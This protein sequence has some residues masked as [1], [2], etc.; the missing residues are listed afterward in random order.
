MCCGLVLVLVD[1]LYWMVL[2]VV[3]YC[4]FDLLVYVVEFVDCIF[5]G[6]WF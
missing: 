6:V 2:C 3:D 1:C 5:V 4:W